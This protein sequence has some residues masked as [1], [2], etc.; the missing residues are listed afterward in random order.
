M[1]ISIKIQVFSVEESQN[2]VDLSDI[3]R[4]THEQKRIKTDS[5]PFSPQSLQRK[6]G[7]PQ[8]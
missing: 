8:T 6:R 3:K 5:S 1:E 4:I 2:L 7:K